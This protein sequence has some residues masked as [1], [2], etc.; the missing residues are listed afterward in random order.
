M[1][2]SRYFLLLFLAGLLLMRSWGVP[3]GGT[4][5]EKNQSKEDKTLVKD[6]GSV[7]PVSTENGGEI[8]LGKLREGAFQEIN[9]D[10]SFPA[11][12]A[13]YFY[14]GSS[15]GNRICLSFDDGPHPQYTPQILSI[16]K[17]KKVKATFFL[18][19]ENAKYYPHVVK[20]IVEAGCEVGNHSYTHPQL[21]KLEPEKIREELEKTQAEIKKAC[22]ISPLVIR[23]PYGVASSDIARIAYEMRLDPFFWSIDTNDYKNETTVE[24]IVKTVMK[25]IKG[26]SIILMHDKSQKV[27]E[28]VKEIIDPIREKGYEFSTCSELAAEA[29]MKNLGMEKKESREIKTGQTIK[30]GE[31][32]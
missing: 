26:G 13:R 29:R 6:K 12:K 4:P 16:L 25:D 24:D 27:V 28:A 3:P 8:D 7:K 9:P 22:G 31:N 15:Q 32:R 2:R 11:R 14:H 10:F 18:T 17:E 30:G 19:G 23:F 5:A 1:K 20:A 21:N